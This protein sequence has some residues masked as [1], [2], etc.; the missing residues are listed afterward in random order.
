MP[1]DQAR[2]LR[3]AMHTPG[4]KQAFGQFLQ[5]MVLDITMWP[6]LREL[7]WNRAERWIPAQEALAL[8]ERNWRFVEGEQLTREETNLVEHLRDKFGGGVLNV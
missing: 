7:A 5:D 3:I 8:Y 2:R 1:A 4:F 6:K